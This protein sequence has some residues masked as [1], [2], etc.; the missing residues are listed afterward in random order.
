M[1]TSLFVAGL[2]MMGFAGFFYVYN[3]NQVDLCNSPV[4]QLGLLLRP[5]LIEGC[6]WNVIHQL[7]FGV[8]FGI[9]GLG[10]MIAGAVKK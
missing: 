4:G 10:I 2:V 8:F 5:D 9:A 3:Q 1:K 6:Q 7:I